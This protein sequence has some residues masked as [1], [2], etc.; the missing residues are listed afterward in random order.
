MWRNSEAR[1]LIKIHKSSY[2]ASLQT[3]DQQ[4]ASL[5]RQEDT[6]IDREIQSQTNTVI[7]RDTR[8]HTCALDRC[9]RAAGMCWL[10]TVRWQTAPQATTCPQVHA[11]D[12]GWSQVLGPVA[13]DRFSCVLH[14]RVTEWSTHKHTDRQTHMTHKQYTYKDI[15]SCLSSI[16][17]IFMCFKHACSRVI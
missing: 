16:W 7:D 14:R 6:N 1:N 2:R 10:P 5:D 12:R 17:A 15:S 11:V 3:T 8:R 13:S 4:P 9:R